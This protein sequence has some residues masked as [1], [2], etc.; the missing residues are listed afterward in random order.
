MGA[1]S[2][3]QT[4]GQYSI[5]D[6]IKANPDI[7]ILFHMDHYEEPI[8][9]RIERLYSDRILANLNVFKNKRI[10]PIPGAD[11]YCP[12]VRAVEGFQALSKI[13]HPDLFPN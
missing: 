3:F 2:S 8:E 4:R 11:L 6:I 13:I 7:I 12:G 9:K 1:K 5:E 10:Y